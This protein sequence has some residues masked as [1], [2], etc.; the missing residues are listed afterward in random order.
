MVGALPEASRPYL[1]D[2]WPLWI[3]HLDD[4]IPSVREDAAIAL[5]DAAAGLHQDALSIILPHLRHA[6]LLATSAGCHVVPADK[7]GW[8]GCSFSSALPPCCEP[9][10]TKVV[11]QHISQQAIKEVAVTACC[12]ILSGIMRSSSGRTAP[13]SGAGLETRDQSSKGFKMTI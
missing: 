3:T 2:L 4:N 8:R 10:V 12:Q 6:R 7:S 11:L 13:E 1:A 9:V 5:G